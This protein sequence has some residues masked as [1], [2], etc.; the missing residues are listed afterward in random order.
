MEIDDLEWELRVGQY[1]W[2][3]DPGF[4]T[5]RQPESCVYNRPLTIMEAH[6]HAI[7]ALFS[8]PPMLLLKEE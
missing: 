8:V 7:L 4:P 6:E 5:H 1:A 2:I 3:P